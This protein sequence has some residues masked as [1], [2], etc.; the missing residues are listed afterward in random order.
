MGEAASRS[1][2]EFS[3]APLIGGA[4]TTASS[5]RERN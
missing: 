1:E 5:S 2:P 4:R 3:P